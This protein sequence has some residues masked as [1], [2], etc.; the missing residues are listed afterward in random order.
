M[1]YDSLKNN[2]EL[3]LAELKQREAEI[4]QLNRVL[5]I[6]RLEAVE[7]K[8][9]LQEKI[10]LSETYIDKSIDKLK[11]LSKKKFIVGPYVGY[12]LNGN[13]LGVNIGLG[14]TYKLLA[15]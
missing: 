4:E 11:R 1:R 9:H 3:A 10:T 15:F 5:D 6:E 14:V 8:T 2:Y 13:Q 7:T 12:G